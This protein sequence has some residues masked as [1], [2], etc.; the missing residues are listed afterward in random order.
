MRALIRLALFALLLCA[1]AWCPEPVFGQEK[2]KAKAPPTPFTEVVRA[3]FETW[4]LD[5][6]GKLTLEEINDA[7]MR[8]RFQGDVAVA[9]AT[10]RS[11]ARYDFEREEKKVRPLTLPQL[12]RYEAAR[13]AGREVE[14]DYD[15]VFKDFQRKLA[16]TPRE[17]FPEKLPRLDA[18]KQ[19]D[20]GDCFFMSM[21]GAMVFMQPEKVC[22]M[23]EKL[24]GRK[25]AVHF[26]GVPRPV[27]I[28][29]PTDAEIALNTTAERNGLWLTVIE[30]AYAARVNRTQPRPKR[31]RS[32]TDAIE[33]G[34][35]QDA[36]AIL[37]GHSCRE[38]LPR[39][40]TFRS[41]LEAA[42]AGRCLIYA[43]IRP[44]RDVPGLYH[45]HQYAVLAFDP[46][47]E[48]V[49]VF[50]P[51]GEDFTPKGKPG[52]RNGFEA[53]A[54]VL[55]LSLKDYIEVFGGIGYE[56]KNSKAE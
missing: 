36:I 4:D 10:L 45:G 19:G 1:A 25:Y 41:E 7:M 31:E 56:D 9:V 26:D 28:G 40:P 15:K 6:D 35:A 49:T 12:Q 13:A 16:A 43:A 38:V 22:R 48:M 3:H 55:T 39:K 37:T 34:F 53:K 17:L 20:V 30:K 2:K 47:T 11:I 51:L 42:V 24:D 44:R 32:P 14:H 50:D 46:R 5:G 21:F 33:G 18:I 54:G 27:V 29:A 8:P 23:I 52:P